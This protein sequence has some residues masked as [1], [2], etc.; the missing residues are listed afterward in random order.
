[1][2]LGT[3]T[4][5]KN[6]DAFFEIFKGASIW[7]QGYNNW[8]WSP[9]KKA[10]AIPLIENGIE[11]DA[12][13]DFDSYDSTPLLLVAEYCHDLEIMLLL[14]EK[15]A[16]VNIQNKHGSTPLNACMHYQPSIEKLQLLLSHHADPNIPD[17]HGMVPLSWCLGHYSEYSMQIIQLLLNNHAK[18]D[19]AKCR[20]KKFLEDIFSRSRIFDP[21]ILSLL[22]TILNKIHSLGRLE[23]LKKAFKDILNENW[24]AVCHCPKE[25]FKIMRGCSEKRQFQI[26]QIIEQQFDNAITIAWSNCSTEPLC[27]RLFNCLTDFPADDDVQDALQ[28]THHE[29]QPFIPSRIKNTR[30]DEPVMPDEAKNTETPFCACYIL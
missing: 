16:N 26:I 8:R 19:I 22:E 13:R 30:K 20:G 11:L 12:H 14:I 1:M 2:I 5:S 28:A 9:E 23:C 4:K 21:E 18:I 3:D 29:A 17:N 24:D 27:L 25:V 10:A 6:T 7:G 15:G